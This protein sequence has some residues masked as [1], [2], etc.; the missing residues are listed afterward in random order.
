MLYFSC[1]HIMNIQ[2]SEIFCVLDAR[3]SMVNSHIFFLF[4]LR[5]IWNTASWVGITLWSLPNFGGGNQDARSQGANKCSVRIS[6]LHAHWYIHMLLGWCRLFNLSTS[7]PGKEMQEIKWNLRLDVAPD[8]KTQPP[9]LLIFSDVARHV[10]LA[11]DIAH[12]LMDGLGSRLKGNQFHLCRTTLNSLVVICTQKVSSL[13][14]H[15]PRIY[16]KLCRFSQC[17]YKN[18]WWYTRFY[19]VIIHIIF[20]FNATCL[21]K[22]SCIARSSLEYHRSYVVTSRQNIVHLFSDTSYEQRYLE[23]ATLDI[24]LQQSKLAHSLAHRCA[25]QGPLKFTIEWGL[26]PPL[27][28]QFYA[29][30]CARSSRWPRGQGALSRGGWARRVVPHEELHPKD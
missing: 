26:D 8:L 4:N 19:F 11:A 10:S 2:E 25:Y 29:T 17:T 23:A 22:G 7:D 21:F 14:L 12:D 13:W 16:K 5:K 6:N 1:Q 15:G 9:V 20:V 27:H 18:P 24:V 3:I 28:I 30:S